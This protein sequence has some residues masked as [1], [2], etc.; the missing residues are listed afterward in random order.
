M[1][2]KINNVIAQETYL[3]LPE[4]KGEVSVK[5]SSEQTPSSQSPMQQSPAFSQ[6]SPSSMH[7]SSEGLFVDSFVGVTVGFCDGASVG[8]DI[9][10]GEAV[11][12]VD[13]VESCVGSKEAGG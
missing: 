10:T 1:L 11:V 2:E 7:G 6:A 3:V 4:V 13:V 8:G 5:T 9:S 12:V